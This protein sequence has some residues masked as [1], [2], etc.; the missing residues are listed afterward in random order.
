M[1]PIELELGKIVRKYL[2]KAGHSQ[3][4]FADV[5]G[6]PRTYISLI[7]LGKVPALGDVFRDSDPN[8]TPGVPR[9][10]F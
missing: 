6:L 5:A 9:R 2:E 10:S 3:A 8:P 4:G 1:E 7:E